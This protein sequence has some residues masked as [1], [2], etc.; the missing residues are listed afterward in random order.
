MSLY[1]PDGGFLTMSTT[2][3]GLDLSARFVPTP[4]HFFIRPF[5]RGGGGFYAVHVRVDDSGAGNI[6]QRDAVGLA[7]YGLVGGGVEITSP[8]VLP[9]GRVV[10]FLAGIVVEGGAR[11]GGGG[12]TP[13][14][15]SAAL[16]DLGRMDLGPWYLRVAA[17]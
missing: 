2:V 13:A 17:R 12:P 6:G 16:G 10:P 8:T 3:R 7:P 11:I 1:G 15:P 9:S 4:P 14:A 5:V